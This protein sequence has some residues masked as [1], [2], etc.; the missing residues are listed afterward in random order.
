[1]NYDQIEN[2]LDRI[3][4]LSRDARKA[5]AMG[6]TLGSSSHGCPRDLGNEVG[7]LQ[8]HLLNGIYLNITKIF[9]QHKDKSYTLQN[10]ELQ[11]SN[12]DL[13][14]K[15][16]LEAHKRFGCDDHDISIKDMIR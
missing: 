11:L 5:F 10:I 8:R 2:A 6:R 9:D 7:F 13:D 4:D 1:M 12:C 15:G 3:L 14:Y 16:R